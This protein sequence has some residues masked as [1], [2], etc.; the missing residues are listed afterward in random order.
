MDKIQ[1]SRKASIDFL[2]CTYSYYQT[3]LRTQI[4]MVSVG[5]FFSAL[6]LGIYLAHNK[7]VVEGNR[8]KK[9]DGKAA[10]IYVP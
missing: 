10:Q 4:I 5:I 7:R 8:G 1:Q 9:E 2:V 6:Q 3:G